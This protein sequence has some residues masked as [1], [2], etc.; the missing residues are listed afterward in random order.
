MVF[1]TSA[2][3]APALE[4]RIERRLEQAL[5]FAVATFLRTDRQLAEVLEHDVLQDLGAHA[6]YIGFLREPPSREVQAKLM[7]HDSRSDSFHVS[8]REVYWLCRTPRMSDSP[9]FKVGTRKG[10]RRDGDR[11]QRD[12]RRETGGEI[13]V[14][15][16]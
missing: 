8:G 12:D 10:A 1:E 4:R 14:A 2:T 9:F 6:V 3:D 7:R 5:G 13:S 15:R 11:P 16:R